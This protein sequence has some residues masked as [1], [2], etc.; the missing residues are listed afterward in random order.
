V[1]VVRF[2]RGKGEGEGIVGKI[3]LVNHQV[4]RN[5]GGRTF[6]TK[7]LETE[8]ERVRILKEDFAINLVKEEVAGIKGR[9]VEIVGS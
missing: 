8:E 9:N 4:K 2:L 7:V 1:L 3:M 5:D 6:V